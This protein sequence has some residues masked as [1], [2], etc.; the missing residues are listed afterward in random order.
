MNSLR[1][2][3]NLMIHNRTQGLDN[4]ADILGQMREI[5]VQAVSAN[6]SNLKRV[7]LELEFQMLKNEITRIGESMEHNNISL[8]IPKKSFYA[9]LGPNGAGKTTTIGIL[10]GLI[11]PTSGNAT[12]FDYDTIKEYRFS[13]KLIG[14]SPQ[15]LNF[16]VFF[17][18]EELLFLQAGYYG[19]SKKQSSERIYSLLEQFELMDKKNSTARELSGGMKR[20]VQIVK[21]LVHDPPILILDEPTAGVDIELRYKLWDVLKELNKYKTILLTTHYIEEAEK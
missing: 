5:A 8:N 6:T 16:D 19:L 18:I 13:R 21:S 15:E 14:L 20:R 12:V 3:R 7:S 10:I 4:I 2:N 9:I 1:T 11:N 17:T